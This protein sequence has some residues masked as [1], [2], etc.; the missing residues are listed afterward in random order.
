VV[1]IERSVIFTELAQGH[2]SFSQQIDLS[3]YL[4][5]RFFQVIEK[6]IEKN[7]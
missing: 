4:Y 5:Y 6:W 2:L 3:L 7:I 1:I